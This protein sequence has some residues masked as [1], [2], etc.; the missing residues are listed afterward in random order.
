[1][2]EETKVKKQISFDEDKLELLENGDFNLL[3]T[4]CS[5][6]G[7]VSPGRHPACFA[8]SSRK[9]KIINMSKTGTLNNY[10]NV[11][12]KPSVEWKGPL[13]YIMAEV[14][15]EGSAVNTMLLGIDAKDVKKG[16]KVKLAIEKADTNEEG[17]DIMIYVWRPA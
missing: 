10:S 8:C 1:M 12:I 11:L 5:E 2:A 3:G 17:D 13:P 6:C 16:M 15:T 9:I 4:K 14:M 7:T